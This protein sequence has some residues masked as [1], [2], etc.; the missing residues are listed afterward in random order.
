MIIS[1]EGHAGTGKSNFIFS[2]PLKVVVFS[3]DMGHNRALYGSMF[4]K[5]YEGL[6]IQKVP[7]KAGTADKVKD[8]YKD[9]DITVYELPSPIQMDPKKVI[10]CTEQWSY[11][12]EIYVHLFGDPEVQTIGIDTM[13]LLRKLRIDA[14][15][16]E[17]QA[18]G[19]PREQLMQIEY[20]IPD[21][22]IRNL[23]GLANS[24]QRNLIVSHHLRDHY[25]SVQ[26]DGKVETVPD[27]TF[28]IDGLKDTERMVDIFMRTEKT[29]SGELQTKMTKCGYDLTKEGIPIVEA[30]WDK[31]INMISLSWN[32]EPFPVRKVKVNE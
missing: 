14:R 10:G 8:A 21:G 22:D 27:G 20:G 2:G 25:V 30:T 12:Q 11:F 7:Y 15:I 5:F 1:V 9:F 23:Y 4:K 6:K 32:G 26:K 31:V 17:L 28:E 18:G 13:T 29:K 3:T 16:Q 19:K 24:F